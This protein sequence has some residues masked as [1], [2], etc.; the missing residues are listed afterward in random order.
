M[1]NEVQG[2]PSMAATTRPIIM[3]RLMRL[4][5][6]GEVRSAGGQ[7]LMSN[8]RVV[9]PALRAARDNLPDPEKKSARYSDL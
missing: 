5:S 2:G 3:S 8:S 6:P 4:S 9:K 1:L 7:L